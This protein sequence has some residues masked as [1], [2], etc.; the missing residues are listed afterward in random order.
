MRKLLPVAI[1]AIV[2][3]LTA[4]T[5]SEE[6]AG[7]PEETAAAPVGD[8]QAAAPDE[9]GVRMI[10]ISTPKGDFK[11]WTRQVGDNPRIKVLLLHGGPGATYELFKP[12]ED[13]FTP[14]G[15][16]FFY[17][18]QLD[19]WLSDQPNDPDLWTIEAAVS[20]VKEQHEEHKE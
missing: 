5:P 9:A 17:Y 10:P 18:D 11:V 15:I 4:C 13:Y 16:E 12:F 8:V 3:G 6:P 20:E 14:A 19:S 1:S 2:L 7:A